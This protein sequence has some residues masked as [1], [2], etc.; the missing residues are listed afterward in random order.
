MEAQTVGG[1]SQA[2]EGRRRG[3]A[4][5]AY[6]LWQMTRAAFLAEEKNSVLGLLWHF[7]NPL[8]M[9]TVLYVT[10]SSIG[11]PGAIDQYPLFILVGIIHFN[12]FAN[13]TSRAAEGMSK[14][15][16]LVLNT[17]VPLEMLVLRQ[18]CI[19]GLTLAIELVL[20]CL[21]ISIAGGG[22]G[23]A[24][25][26]YGVVIV[27]LFMLTFGT[28]L[29]LSTVVVFITDV[30]YVWNMATRMLFFLTPIFYATEGI[31]S[32]PLRIVTALNPLAGAITMAR[33]TLLYGRAAAL[34]HTVAVVV[35][36]LAVLVLGWEVFQRF[37]GRI[38]DYI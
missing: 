17:T 1:M 34:W 20:V 3:T 10:I 29:L 33:E 21:L 11:R 9:T 32:A 13:A 36:P 31:N 12:F 38:P 4:E 8:A 22:L 14:S 35:A 16:S 2:D 6:L 23:A 7:L 15:R 27:G 30:T 19:E 28:S 37:K 25:L 26:G 24:A 5:L 18:V